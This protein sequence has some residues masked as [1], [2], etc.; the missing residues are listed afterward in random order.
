[1]YA[2]PTR[3]LPSLSRLPLQSCGTKRVNE[4]EGGGRKRSSV[5][6]CTAHWEDMLRDAVQFFTD[7]LL[8]ACKPFP[9]QPQPLRYARQFCGANF[10]GNRDDSMKFIVNAKPI[11]LPNG[12]VSYMLALRMSTGT[13]NED[14]A[15]R[16][17]F[18][19]MARQN[20]GMG[21]RATAVPL[22]AWRRQWEMHPDDARLAVVI[23]ETLVGILVPWLKFFH[24]RFTYQEN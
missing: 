2:P 24:A 22:D 15:T 20:P 21:N 13:W 19:E 11:S 18:D 9:G 10:A 3:P 6:Q 5:L 14:V 17:L 8:A 12:R 23:R 1:M 16:W 4:D 7:A